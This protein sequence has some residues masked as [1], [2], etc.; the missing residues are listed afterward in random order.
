MSVLREPRA[1]LLAAVIAMAWKFAFAG[2]GVPVLDVKPSCRAAASRGLGNITTIERCVEQETSA[3]DDLVQRWSTFE[4]ADRQ[5]CIAQTSIGGIP[6][7]VELLTCITI[8][9]DARALEKREAVR[10]RASSTQGMG[11]R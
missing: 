1:L 5:Q 4:P 2:D 7:Y 9:A 10:G 11:G 3:H 6:S 8:A